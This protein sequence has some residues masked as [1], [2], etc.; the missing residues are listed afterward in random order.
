[1]ADRGQRNTAQELRDGNEDLFDIMTLRHHEQIIVTA[2]NSHD[3]AIYVKLYGAGSRDPTMAD[4]VLDT[5]MELAIGS[6]TEQRG[7]IVSD[8]QWRYIRVGIISTGGSPSTGSSDVEIEIRR[9]R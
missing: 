6:V 8:V 4:K 2:T 3:E 5:Q 7:S 1:M 9:K